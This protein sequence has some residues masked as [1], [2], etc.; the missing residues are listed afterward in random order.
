MLHSQIP[1]CQYVLVY[2]NKTICILVNVTIKFN[3]HTYQTRTA[4]TST[5]LYIQQPRKDL[6]VRYTTNILRKA[7]ILYFILYI[8]T[9]PFYQDQQSM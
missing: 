4:I 6:I 7:V 8:L 5:R 9:I 1:G 2:V 3:Y